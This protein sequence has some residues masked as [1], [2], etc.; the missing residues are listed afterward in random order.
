MSTPTT[1][2][3]VISRNGWSFRHAPKAS[4]V[5]IFAEGALDEKVPYDVFAIPEWVTVAHMD[6][7]ALSAVADT[8]LRNH[9]P[10]WPGPRP[11]EVDGAPELTI[12]QSRIVTRPQRHVEYK[13]GEPISSP[14]IPGLVVEFLADHTLVVRCQGDVFPLI[15]P[16]ASNTFEVFTENILDVAKRQEARA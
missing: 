7:D 8:W 9:A 1:K 6:N 13:A 16:T 10:A 4:S 15:R 2:L 12:G 11:D 3:R 14:L 5:A